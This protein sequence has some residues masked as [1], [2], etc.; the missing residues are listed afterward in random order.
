MHTD[1]LTAWDTQTLKPSWEVEIPAKRANILMERHM[2]TMSND[3]RFVYIDNFT[4]A[5]SVTVVDTEAQD[6][7]SEIDI[8]GCALNY[9]IGDRAFASICGDGS[10]QQINL[11]DDGQEAS[12]TRTKFFDPNETPMNE[13]AVRDGDMYYFTTLDGEIQPIDV[14]G[15][16]PKVGKR[17]SLFTDAQ[18]EEG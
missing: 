6:V 13:R 8:A 18:R 17:W 1:V 7:A 5:T 12:R 9:P 11:D 15:K 4:P 3:D 14:S 2:L 16:T 10:F